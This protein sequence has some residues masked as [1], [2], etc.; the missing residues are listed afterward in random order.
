MTTQTSPRAL[1]VPRL[2]YVAA[3]EIAL[4][5]IGGGLAVMFHVNTLADAV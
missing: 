1:P 2:T 5:L 4:S 3:A